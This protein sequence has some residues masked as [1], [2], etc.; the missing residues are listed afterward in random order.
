MT[1]SNPQRS[2]YL[3]LLLA[4]AFY[5]P[6]LSIADGTGPAFRTEVPFP[7]GL[8]RFIHQLLFSSLDPSTNISE[9]SA[10]TSTAAFEPLLKASHQSHALFDERR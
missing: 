5:P 7:R 8:R 4:A 9:S 10:M 3:D 1:M 2:N 6:R